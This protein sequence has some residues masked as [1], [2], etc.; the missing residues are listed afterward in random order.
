MKKQTLIFLWLF[1]TGWLFPSHE[2]MAHPT[3]NVDLACSNPS[4]KVGEPFWLAVRFT[5]EPGWHLYAPNT[6]EMGASMHIHW[7]PPKN[8]KIIQI[9]WP[10]ARCLEQDSILSYV[11]EKEVWVL[12]KVLLEKPLS[13]KESVFKADI[14]WVACQETCIPGKSELSLDLLHPTNLV[15]PDQLNIWLE[16]IVNQDDPE[17]DGDWLIPF[18]CAFLGGILLNLMPCVLP[19]LSLKIL[20]LLKPQNNPSYL[21]YH[22]WAFTGG[23]LMSF[24]ILASVLLGLRAGGQ[25]LGWGF[26]LQSPLFVF[27]L[28]CLFWVLALNLW[29]VFEMGVIFTRFQ[30]SK[31]HHSLLGT[32]SNGVLACVVASPCTAPFMGTAL[33]FALTQSWQIGLLIFLGLGLGMAMPFLLICLVPSLAKLLPKP[34]AWME[35]L[36]HFLGFALCGTVIWLLWIIGHQQGLDSVLKILIGLLAMGLGGWIWGRWAVPYRSFKV[37]FLSRLIGTVLMVSPVAMIGLSLG[38]LPSE[39]TLDWQPYK[40]QKLQQA[41]DEGK[42]VFIDFTAT[43]CLTCQIN[44]KMALYHPKV[45]ETL[46]KM[47]IVTLRADW[48]HHDPLITRALAE[49]GRTSIPLYVLY[50]KNKKPQILPTLLT[51][52]LLVE[53][54]E[55][56]SYP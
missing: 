22:G 21:R 30:V 35:S 36:K 5:I 33:G 25:E 38:S 37:R 17:Y 47:N 24:L 6:D 26:Q 2:I 27:G 4:C 50:G 14:S 13:P 1:I 43:W 10:T 41:L 9:L 42:M 45:I 55:K 51:P 11:Y 18:L 49:Y 39:S 3:V 56:L 44:K 12:V 34:G 19:V 16:K 53:A 15:N 23:V 54:L 52:T 28:A 7:T 48:T 20:D 46:K 8:L 40:A 29:G 31:N 32:F